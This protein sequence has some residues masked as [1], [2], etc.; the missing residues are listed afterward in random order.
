M[1][2]D[3]QQR[4]RCLLKR[5]RA[6]VFLDRARIPLR[7]ALPIRFIAYDAV[8]EWKRRGEERQKFRSTSRLLAP[9][10]RSAFARLS[11]KLRGAFASAAAQN[12]SNIRGP[13]LFLRVRAVA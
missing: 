1:K 6:L 13:V 3:R 11:P 2:G 4:Q 10:V 7:C 9:S 8:E 5:E 12:L